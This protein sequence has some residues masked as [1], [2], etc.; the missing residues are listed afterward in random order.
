M[1]LPAMA[2]VASAPATDSSQ[3]ADSDG[4]HCTATEVAPDSSSSSRQPVG[5]SHSNS[6]TANSGVRQRMSGATVAVDGAY[7]PPVN[8]Q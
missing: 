6:G 1:F 2:N 3:A 5:N 8:G 7:E 4:V